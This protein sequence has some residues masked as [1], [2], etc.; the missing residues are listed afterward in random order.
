MR[1]WCAEP[2]YAPETFRDI[3]RKQ[4]AV[5]ICAS[6]RRAQG[7]IMRHLA[8]YTALSLAFV[9]ALPAEAQ[10]RTLRRAGEDVLILNVRPR[11]YLDAGNVVPVGSM[12]NPASGLGQTQSYLNL[13]PYFGQ[14]ERFGAS[15]LPDPIANGPYPG[16]NMRNPFDRVF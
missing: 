2:R 14:R 1:D 6:G 12:N 5:S 13:P 10:T 3:R 9:G 4:Q 8:I 15:V 16:P 7:V 11:S